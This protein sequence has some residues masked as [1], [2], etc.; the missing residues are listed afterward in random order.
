MGVPIP[1]LINVGIEGIAIFEAL[2]D[3]VRP[4]D[5]GGLIACILIDTN[6]KAAARC[7]IVRIHLGEV[8][9]TAVA[10]II[11]GR[12][13]QVQAVRFAIYINGFDVVE[14]CGDQLLGCSGLFN[15]R[16]LAT[17]HSDAEHPANMSASPF[18]SENVVHGCGGIIERMV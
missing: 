13:I 4:D 2:P 15:S 5:D 14:V 18:V 8:I 17:I 3:I 10:Y 9:T 11:V 6:S 1:E 7:D 12:I 16:D